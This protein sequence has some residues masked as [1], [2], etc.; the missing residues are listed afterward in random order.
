MDVRR[1]QRN[2]SRKLA[3]TSFVTDAAPHPLQDHHPVHSAAAFAAEPTVVKVLA[4]VSGT[5]RSVFL[6]SQRPEPT[7]YW[8]GSV[9]T[10]SGRV[11]G[12]VLV[13]EPLAEIAGGIPGSTFYDLSGILLVTTVRT[14]P[15]ASSTIR[16]AITP[17]NTVGADDT[18]SGHAY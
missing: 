9:R 1:A 16:H 5:D 13:G 10:A 2:T 11:V 12:A 3:E 17:D 4:G 6:R 18:Q 14:P 15:V 8:T 7:V